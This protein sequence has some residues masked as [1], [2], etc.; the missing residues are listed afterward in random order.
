MRIKAHAYK[1]VF[2]WVE[3]EREML[4]IAA[5]GELVQILTAL[6]YSSHDQ[7]KL[8]KSRCFHL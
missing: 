4:Q 7:G 5:R 1:S 2:C 3:K 6:Q 8:V